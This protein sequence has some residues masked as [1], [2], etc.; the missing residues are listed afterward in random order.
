MQGTESFIITLCLLCYVLIC[1]S[2]HLFAEQLLNPTV[3][4]RVFLPWPDDSAVQ[5]HLTV[6][7]TQSFQR[8]PNYN[9]GFLQ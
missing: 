9:P 5:T 6:P 3:S 8:L 2:Q 4:W 7:S 1:K